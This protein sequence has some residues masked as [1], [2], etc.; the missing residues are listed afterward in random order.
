MAWLFTEYDVAWNS[1]V[2]HWNFSIPRATLYSVNSQ[3]PVSVWEKTAVNWECFF[4]AT[5]NKIYYQLE[6][7]PMTS[8]LSFIFISLLYEHWTMLNKNTMHQWNSVVKEFALATLNASN[9]EVTCCETFSPF[10]RFS[11]AS[12]VTVIS[13]L[14][15]NQLTLKCTTQY[16]RVRMHMYYYEEFVF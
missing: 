8:T 11:A 10:G 6:S 4:Y 5:T 13:D 15:T 12:Q 16:L 2:L 1:Q 9:H 14:Y 7:W 3:A